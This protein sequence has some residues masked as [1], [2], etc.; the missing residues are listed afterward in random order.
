LAVA[1]SHEYLPEGYQNKRMWY[2]YFFLDQWGEKNFEELASLVRGLHGYD[3]ARTFNETLRM[4]KGVQNTSIQHP[5]TLYIKDKIYLDGFTRVQQ[6]LDAGGN[7]DD[8]MIGKI[9]ISDL[10]YIV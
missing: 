2:R 10:K 1:V 4:K 5:W 3:L 8:L 9:K 6:R 7:K